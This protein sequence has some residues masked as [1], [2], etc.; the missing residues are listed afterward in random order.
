L[1]SPEINARQYA[2]PALPGF[3]SFSSLLTI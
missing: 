2:L 1:E 3:D